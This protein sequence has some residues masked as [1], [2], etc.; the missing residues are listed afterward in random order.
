MAL[1]RAEVMA[2][3]VGL[4]SAVAVLAAPLSVAAQSDKGARVGVL[5]PAPDDP[6]FR[7]MFEPFKQTLR[8]RGFEEGTNLIIELRV[9]PGSAAEMLALARE[10]VHLKMDTILAVSPAGVNAAA[11]ATQSIPIVAIDLES[12]PKTAGFAVSLNRPMRN[13]TGLFLD[14]PELSGKWI[15]LLKEVVPNLGKV[16]VVADRATG[17]FFREELEATARSLRVKLLALEVSRPEDLQGAF[18]SAARQGAAGLLVLP[19]PMVNSARKQIAD[20]AT[21][22]RMPAIMPFA[23]F[24]EDGGLIAYGPDILAIYGQAGSV[25]ARVLRGAQPR[26][27]PI[28]RPT[29]FELILNMQTAKAFGLKIS[30]SF[31]LRANRVIE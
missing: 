9:R 25:V 10:L 5:R 6:V 19:S 8:E 7:Q 15:E 31:L 27:I 14:L 29:R 4:I 21:K 1:N 18:Q 11:Q 17:R 23:G 26:E 20:L 2:G 13:V 12:D 24:A 30:N 22:Y 16:A 3:L 28:E